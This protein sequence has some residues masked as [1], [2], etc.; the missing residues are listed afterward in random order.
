MRHGAGS[1]LPP[2]EPRSS[3][4]SDT[5]N[6]SP[7]PYGA[8]S[9]YTKDGFGLNATAGHGNANTKYYGEYLVDTQI[10]LAKNAVVILNRLCYA[11]GT[12][13][14]DRPIRP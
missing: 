12:P 3:S 14:G 1:G 10:N 8:F 5:A 2:R 11:S 6:G 4:T 9:K 7:G 13:S